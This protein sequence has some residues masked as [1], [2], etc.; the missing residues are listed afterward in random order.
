VVQGSESGHAARI[1]I[2]DTETGVARAISPEGALYGGPAS[3]DGKFVAA[4]DSGRRPTLYSIDGG[5]PRVVPGLQTEEVVIRWSSD[6]RSLFVS[7][8]WGMPTSVFRVDVA[9][10]RRELVHRFA[11]EDSAGVINVGPVLLSEDGKSYVYS[12]RRIL[13]D[14]YQIGGLE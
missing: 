2:V 14:L 6:G 5:A 13:H 4:L 8:R 10:G 7:S 12:Y 9:N 3:P 1:Y 11:P